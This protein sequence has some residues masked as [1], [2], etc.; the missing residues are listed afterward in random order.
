MLLL[1][2]AGRTGCCGLDKVDKLQWVESKSLG[3][4]YR[5]LRAKRVKYR[6]ESAL[7]IIDR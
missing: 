5:I 1:D 6:T 7:M 3:R 4:R 2:N